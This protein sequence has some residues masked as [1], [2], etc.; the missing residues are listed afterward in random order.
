MS[1]WRDTDV[2]VVIDVQ[3]AF[4]DSASPWCAEGFPTALDGIERLRDSCPGPAVWTRF[5]PDSTE[6][7]AWHDYYE[8]W[9][10]MRRP[11]DDPLWELLGKPR[12]GDRVVTAPTFSKWGDE[13]AELVPQD[14]RMVLCGVATDCCVLAT[15]LAAVDAGRRVL[16]VDDACA[17]GTRLQHQQAVELMALL[18]PM[19]QVTTVGKIIGSPPV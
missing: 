7:G 5:L 4:G 3:R 18:S 1:V 12:A 10:Q 6:P 8:T 11:V 15:A 14:A 13:M 19:L 9:P 2:L 17:G 16:L